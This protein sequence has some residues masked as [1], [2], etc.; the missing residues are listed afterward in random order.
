VRYGVGASDVVL[1]SVVQETKDGILLQ[2]TVP[3]YNWDNAL[4]NIDK[5]TLMKMV[6]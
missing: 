1:P 5:E 6:I 4:D 3:R 2:N